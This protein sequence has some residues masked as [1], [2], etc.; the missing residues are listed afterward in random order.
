MVCEVPYTALDSF[1]LRFL[2]WPPS[3]M[4]TSWVKTAPSMVTEPNCVRSILGSMA[5]HRPSP[6]M[7]G[8]TRCP[9]TDPQNRP[10]EAAHGT[11]AAELTRWSSRTLVRPGRPDSAK[12]T[13]TLQRQA[14]APEAGDRCH[15]EPAQGGLADEVGGRWFSSSPL[16]RP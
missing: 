15:S 10:R 7:A 2:T 6:P 8:Q 9:R 13:Y 1:F 11:R 4:I 12:P 14:I 5:P 3:R 16:R